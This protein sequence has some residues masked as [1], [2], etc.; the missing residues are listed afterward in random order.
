MYIFVW[1]LTKDSLFRKPFTKI[2]QKI[3]YNLKHVHFNDQINKNNPSNMQSS[4][5][6]AH[7]CIQ[8]CFLVSLTVTP[9]VTL[10]SKLP[11]VDA[12]QGHPFDGHLPDTRGSIRVPW[13]LHMF[14]E[15]LLLNGKESE[16]GGYQ[17]KMF[18]F[19]SANT[20]F[21]SSLSLYNQHSLTHT[22]SHRS[23]HVPAHKHYRTKT[24]Q[25]A[26]RSGT[27]LNTVIRFE[28][29]L[30]WLQCWMLRGGDNVCVCLSCSRRRG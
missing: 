23:T 13:Y 11:V 7:H 4:T 28:G 29:Q 16:V 19:C 5:H 27:Q 25:T 14:L 2:V 8:S 3:F 10:M 18:S 15:L 24:G 22:H 21:E 20:S 30:Y 1:L 26:Q 17:T 9:H 6:V 12:L